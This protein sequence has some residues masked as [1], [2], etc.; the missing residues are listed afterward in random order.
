MQSKI[1]DA[2]FSLP[3][4]YYLTRFFIGLLYFIIILSTGLENGKLGLWWYFFSIPST[5][6]FPYAQY[7]FDGL[8]RSFGLEHM[9]E[10]YD[11]KSFVIMA[12]VTMFV[13]AFSLVI[14]PVYLAYKVF[15]D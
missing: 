1:A 13:W 5:I 11:G 8:M 12:I 6:L 3:S 14:A 7:A 10:V 2:L 9:L 4:G 15:V